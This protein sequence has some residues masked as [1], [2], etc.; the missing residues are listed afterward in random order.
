MESTHFNQ[1]TAYPCIFVRSEGTNL[2]IIVDDL[3]IITSSLETMRRIKDNL[4][5]GFEMKDL[6]KLH[7]CL[8]ITIEY[9]KKCLWMH[10]RQFIHSLLE[11]Y[12]MPQA[13]PSTTPT[14]VNVKLVKDDG[15]SKLVD[16]VCY[17]S[18]E[19]SLL[20]AAIVT[21]PTSRKQWEAS[22]I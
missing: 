19:G 8:G 10:Q 15:V 12:G 4:A 20:F 13:K 6:G 5:T 14:D 3:I 18:T 2:T 21:R 22:Q 1:S 16:P 11:R 17:Q 7:N 9:D